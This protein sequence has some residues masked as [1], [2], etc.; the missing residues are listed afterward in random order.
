VPQYQSVVPINAITGA[1]F[2]AAVSAAKRSLLQDAV[3]TFAGAALNV[4]LLTTPIPEV[5]AVLSP[6]VPTVTVTTF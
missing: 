4:Q 6:A 2:A 1:I 3:V 5:A